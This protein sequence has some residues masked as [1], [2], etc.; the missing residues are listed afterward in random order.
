MDSSS[1]DG[2]TT[3]D[4]TTVLDERE[5]L[6]RY[7]N[8][9]REALVWKVEGLDERAARWPM[10][11]T[12]TNLL[13]LVKH[14]AGVEMGYFGPTFGRE[15]TGTPMPWADDDAAPNVDM[16]ATE[17]ESIEG[18]VGVYR[19]VWAWTDDFLTTAPLDTRGHVAWWPDDRATVT[20]RQVITHLTYDLS[21][22]AGH[23]D[24][25]REL[26]DGAAGL[27][28][29]WSNLPDQPADEWTTYVERL[30]TIANSFTAAP[31]SDEQ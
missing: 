2:T 8:A 24:I 28:A 5:V 22:H 10:T 9:A 23:A 14:A 21:R 25:V 4:H 31:P 18:L 30:R 1:P 29:A 17:D 13:G 26:T 12:G 11:P 27:S 3:S 7:L 20:L 19:E 16:W 6:L 15:W